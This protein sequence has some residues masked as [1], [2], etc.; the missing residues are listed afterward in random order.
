VGGGGTE[1]GVNGEL[2]EKKIGVR[3]WP[4]CGQREMALGDMNKGAACKKA[5]D[6][7]GETSREEEGGGK[8]TQQKKIRG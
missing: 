8:F 3:W 1:D 7:S 2:K 4:P 6:A 5:R